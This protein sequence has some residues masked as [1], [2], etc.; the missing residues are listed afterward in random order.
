MTMAEETTQYAFELR[1]ISKRFGAVEA[2]R[3]VSLAARPAAIHALC[4]E[5]GA[6]KSVL[7]GILAGV[8]RPDSGEILIRGESHVFPSPAAAVR[9]G[10]SVVFQESDL[11]PDL[12]VMENVFLGSERLRGVRLA[13]ILDSEGMRRETEELIDCYG[14][15]LKPDALIADLTPPRRQQVEILKALNRRARIL[16][17]DEPAAS[18]SLREAQEFFAILRGLRNTGMTVVYISHRL[19]DLLELADEVTVLR[20]GFRVFSGARSAVNS[21]RVVRYMVGRDPDDIYP[22]RE[23]APGAVFFEARDLTDRAGRVIRAGFSLRSGEIVGLAGLVGSGRSETAKLISGVRRPASGMIFI[24]GIPVKFG[25]P[26]AAGKRKIAFV[27]DDRTWDG[28]IPTL[29]GASNLLLASYRRYG[30]RFLVPPW[31]ELRFAGRFGRLFRLGWPS[32]RTRGAELPAGTRRKL[33]IARRMVS[34]VRLLIL[35]EPTRGVDVESRREIYDLMFR[36]A[37][38]G[39]TILLVSSDLNELF[40][41]TDRILV[42]RGGRVAGDLKTAESSPEEVMRLAAVDE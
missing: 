33:Q 22:V 42:M 32:P 18:L 41:V 25:S 40:G 14:F 21:D 19:G 2:L 37:R 17:L 20:D 15:L 36:F 35:D 3:E 13:H 10:V 1:N 34:G 11:A 6:G 24:D 31:R 30:M 23:S 27:P 9:A 8:Y 28:I 16:V 4:G 29:S 7:S 26:R 39:R 38:R 12:S 5:N